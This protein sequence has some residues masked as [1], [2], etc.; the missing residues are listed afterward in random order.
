MSNSP[1]SP[2]DSR[3][4]LNPTP[5]IQRDG[6]LIFDDDDGEDDGDDDDDD[7]DDDDDDW[8]AIRV[9]L[10]KFLD[11]IQS[12]AMMMM[13]KMEQGTRYVVVVLVA[14]VVIVAVV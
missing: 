6:M 2:S 7:G 4:L 13:I 9:A 3:P 5:P 1:Q 11:T 14:I 8:F 12:N 10:Y